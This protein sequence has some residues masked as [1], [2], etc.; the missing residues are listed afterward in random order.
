MNIRELETMRSAL[1]RIAVDAGELLERMYM[2]KDFT[3]TMKED[4][5]PV[6]SADLQAQDIIMSALAVDFPGVPVVS[7]ER[8]E[9][10][11]REAMKDYFFILDPLDSTKNFITGIPFFDVSIAF[12]HQGQSLV[13]VV[14]DPIHEVTYGAARG[15]GALRNGSRIAVRP[16]HGLSVADFDINATALPT[17]TYATVAL[18]IAPH[19]KKVR[20]FGSA[21]LETC[22]VASGTLDGVLNH[23]LS[24][25]DLA[26]VSLVLEEAGGYWGDL[27]GSPYRFDSIEKR[28]FLA[29][30]DRRLFDE[31]TS[32]LLQ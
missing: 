6:T 22:W 27:S 28:P 15:H 8:G 20:Y 23:K 18:H 19:A 30:G 17:E 9:T 2:R 1:T 7:E 21:V 11:N 29:C 24:S 5:S 14:R 10:L 3:I 12:V 4:G 32:L 26:A 13:G 31:I 25:W 16:C